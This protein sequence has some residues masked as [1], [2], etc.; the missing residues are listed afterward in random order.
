MEYMLQCRQN[1]KFR[2]DILE[3][4]RKKC[5]RNDLRSFSHSVAHESK[6]RK[7]K[8]TNN[9]SRQEV[10][11]YD[12]RNVSF[13][14]SSQVSSTLP[15]DTRQLYLGVPE[16]ACQYCG[17]LC[18]YEE[19]IY[20][21]RNETVPRFFLCCQEG[22]VAL[23][24]L[25]TPPHFLGSLLQYRGSAESAKF[26]Q[27]IR[28]Y[29][30]LFAFTSIGAKIDNEINQRR[31]PYVFKISGQN[32][33]RM[34]SLLPIDGQR[35]KFAQLYIY[36]TENE[37]DNRMKAINTIDELQN[38]DRNVVHSLIEM[39]DSS[40][41]IVKAFRMARDR[42]RESGCLRIRL[43]LIG[44]RVENT[45]QYNPPSCSEIA[46]LIV[47]DLGCADRHRDI[48]VEHKTQ[49][50]KR[51]SDLH[52][53]FMA[54]QYPILFPY[55][56]DGFRVNIKYNG[57]S[58]RKVGTRKCVTMREFYAYRIHNRMAEGRTLISGG[59]LFQRISVGGR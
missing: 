32:Y 30:S 27:N 14:G 26:C 5:T 56:E 54:M 13:S 59:K 34:G 53:S 37:I 7:R 21:S 29:N 12:S 17:A 3:R 22:K 50:L 45:S 6:S 39:F 31:G 1:R 10:G 20:K 52:P 44:S 18:W 38:I 55:G 49:G 40:N 15:H 33:H 46:G 51:I 19:R 42:F 2:K 23:Q 58:G 16:Y 9:I 41:E 24:L 11:I 36:D 8:R 48:V 47:G 57:S 25:Q 4:R 43:R 28:L 35:P